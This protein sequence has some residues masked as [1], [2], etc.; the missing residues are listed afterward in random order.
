MS[1]E[2]KQPSPHSESKFI[3]LG[4][5]REV[6][7]LSPLPDDVL[8]PLAEQMPGLPDEPHYRENLLTGVGTMLHVSIA[9]EPL[10]SVGFDRKSMERILLKCL[11][12]TD[13]ELLACAM[14]IFN[15]SHREDLAKSYARLVEGMPVN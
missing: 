10:N 6:F 11:S 14:Q 12:M 5:D 2:D 9:R 7:L 13:Q 1:M 3:Y 8:F 15:Y 4:E